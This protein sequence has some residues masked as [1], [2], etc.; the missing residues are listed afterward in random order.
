[1]SLGLAAT[2]AAVA[3]LL[4]LQHRRRARL[5]FPIALHTG[6]TP[7]PVPDSLRPADAAGSRVLAARTGGTLLDLMPE[8][9]SVPAPIG[10]DEHGQEVGLFAVPGP[11]V[12]LDGDGA[13]AAARAI[14]TAVLAT[15]VTDY[16]P[17]R[18]VL[19]TPA[20][21]LAQLLPDDVAPH[22]LDPGHETFDGE[23]LIVV[24]DVA[25]AVTHL[26]TEMI[27]RRRLLDDMGVETGDELNARAG[28]GRRRP[29][30]GAAPPP[31]HPRRSARRLGGGPDARRP[32]RG[33]HHQN[34]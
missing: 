13:P 24:P 15:G 17:T 16:L 7:A 21:T 11:A 32:G 18:P 25:A 12:T 9:P 3:A 33:L 29:L 10:T 14:I 19:V 4:R 5:A 31:G 8:T 30:A 6:P 20:D 26:E 34:G 2:I 28:A 27:H 23:R 22:G 1:V